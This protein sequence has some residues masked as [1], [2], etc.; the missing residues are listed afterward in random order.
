MRQRITEARRTLRRLTVCAFTVA[1][2]L[3]AGHGARAQ[4]GG[5]RVVA[6]QLGGDST[7]EYQ[8][9]NPAKS[10]APDAT[11]IVCVWRVVNVPQQGATLRGVWIATD[12]G[13]VAPP[14]FQ[15]AE[16]SYPLTQAGAAGGVFSLSK[17]NAGWPP[18]QYRV[19]LYLDDHLAQSLQFSIYTAA[20]AAAYAQIEPL[21]AQAERLEGQG[22]Y[23]AS[24]DALRRALALSEQTLGPEHA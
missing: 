13:G 7:P 2:A 16:K 14:N 5:A 20:A 19:E 10:F 6:A 23:R 1:V 24:A 4:S 8:I 17:P 22:D 21:I 11:Q 9:I 18:G 3:A 12:T 15:I